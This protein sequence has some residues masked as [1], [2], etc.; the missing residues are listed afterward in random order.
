MPR[1]AREA[2]PK[3]SVRFCVWQRR[4]VRRRRQRVA[5]HVLDESLSDSV[6]YVGLDPRRAQDYLTVWGFDERGE[7]VQQSNGREVSHDPLA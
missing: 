7:E 1:A 3:P 4:E 2:A 6:L 5:Q